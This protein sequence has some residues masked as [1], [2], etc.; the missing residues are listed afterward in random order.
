MTQGVG[1]GAVMR[2]RRAAPRFLIPLGG[3][4]TQGVGPERSQTSVMKR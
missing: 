4:M 1:L 3:R 2:N